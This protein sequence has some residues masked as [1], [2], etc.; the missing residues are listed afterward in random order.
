MSIMTAEKAGAKIVEWYSCVIAKSHDQAI[1]LKE[2]VKQLLSEMKDNDKILAYYSLVEFRHDMLINR[3]NKN[4]LQDDFQ[5]IEHIA[6]IDNMLKY[7]YYFVSGQSEYVNER[8]RSAIK[9]FNKAQRLLEYVNDEAEEAEF[10]QYSGLVYYRLNQ[11][12]VAASHIEHAKVI[13]DRLEYTEPSL[14]CQIV[15]AGIYQ[16][17]HNPK[18]AEDILLDGL[19]KATDND[20]MLGLIN[21]S[22][23]LNKLGIKDYNQAEFYF[24]QALSFKV[25]KDAAVGAKTTYNLSNVLFNQGKHEEAMKQFKAAHAG[26][27]YY[28]N[29]EY[30][31][32]CLATEGLHIKK[33]YSLVDTAIDDLNK[34][35]LDFEVAEVAEEAA[36]FAEKE[37]NDKLTLKYL[38]TAYKARLFQNTLGDDQ[39]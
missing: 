29:H 14:N 38:K 12:L 28:K 18:K 17:L 26:A 6:K 39:Q 16:E 7:L 20:V 30:M 19:E 24:R 2:E 4:E 34:L 15:L 37:G 8:Y 35:G 33:D 32:R 9:L 21:R 11:Y 13:F 5:N 3:Y 36:N 1:L 31:A 23:G 22:L 25:H 10:Y 27:K